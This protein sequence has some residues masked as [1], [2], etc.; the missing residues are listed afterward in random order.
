MNKKKFSLHTLLL[1]LV[2]LTLVS[3]KEEIDLGS[4]I[5]KEP[6]M[7][8]S[9]ETLNVSKSDSTYEI[10]ITSNLPW[11]VKSNVDWIIVKD[12]T[13]KGM[14]TDSKIIVDVRKNPTTEER[15]GSITAWITSDYEKTFSITQA[16]GDPPPVIKKHVYVKEGGTGDGSSWASATSLDAALSQDYAAGD[17]IH[18]AAGTY[19]PG[20]L[21]TGG[22]AG[23]E[24]DKTFEIKQ[25]ITIIGG[26][27][28]NASQ[29]AVSDP[30]V[31]STIL[32]GNNTANHV[33]IVT[34]PVI[35][36]QKVILTGITIKNG[37]TAASGGVS[38]NGL[39]YGKNYGGGLIV[40]K[41]VVELNYCILTDNTAVSGGGAIYTFAEAVLTLNNCVVKNNKTTASGAN[42]GA[43]FIF[44]RSMLYTNHSA[45][46]T[47]GAGGFAGALY[48]YGANFHMYN[49]A[50]DGNGAGGVGSTV[51]G[52]AY[53]GVY[54]RE[55]TG[56]LVNC[57][58][59]GNTASNLGGGVGAY[60]TVSTPA[61]LTIIS[62][63]ITGNKIKHASAKGA[64][65][66]VNATAANAT[67]NI[68]NSIV[69]GNTAGP[70]GTENISD[71]EG[72]AGFA[73]TKKYTIASDQ[74]YDNNGVAIPGTTFDFATMLGTFADN[75]GG[76]NTCL[77]L[78]A[79]NPAKTNGMSANDLIT[80]GNTFTPAIPAEIIANDQIGG[81]RNGKPYIGACV[82]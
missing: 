20:L 42:G 28:A 81:N 68:Y 30:S 49:T 40:G 59:Y 71:V 26:Y 44:G 1:F 39:E 48:A 18:V 4:F 41:S 62:S 54:L 76:T 38:I 23:N 12:A 3:C 11:R 46:T 16:A 78:G 29:G 9:P 73:W 47:N 35:E 10:A 37:N 60:G 75:G 82:K 67:L 51:A 69:S 57:T 79:N 8:F 7:V 27:P 80:L 32:D 36:N 33:V 63:T 66:Y 72:A 25:N 5:P 50:V 55:G 52:K 58:V 43:I 17:L 56:T 14:E 74:V 6:S 61:T 70:S 65:V 19:T 22:S 2:T 24:G 15:V 53:G 21:V 77:L 31:N 34:A 45:I 64:G 13:V